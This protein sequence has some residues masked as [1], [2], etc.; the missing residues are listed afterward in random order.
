L[1]RKDTAVEAVLLLRSVP[2][3]V[4]DPASPIE[5][6]IFLVKMFEID[7]FAKKLNSIPGRQRSEGKLI[8]KR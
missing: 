1:A 2:R 4:V 5:R 6:F 7:V 3:A 8:E